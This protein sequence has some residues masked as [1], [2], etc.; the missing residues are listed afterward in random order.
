MQTP[1]QAT[2]RCSVEPQGMPRRAAL[3]AW[4]PAKWRSALL[5][6]LLLLV[7]PTWAALG[8]NLASI[9]SDQ[10]AWQA[11]HSTSSLP[12]TSLRTLTLS[13]GLTV[14]QYLDTSTD[15][16]FAVAWEGPVLPDFQRLLATQFGAYQD[17]VRA[18]KRGV[19]LKTNDLVIDSGGMMRAFSGRAYL[20]AR[21]PTT[22][23]ASEIR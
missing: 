23:N 10:Q 21:L 5:G 3:P 15:T 2:T 4:R 14:R 18:Q 9:T 20:P 19:H 8:G 7:G 6:G 17:A 22:L 12:G 16:V 11:T 13:N 1:A